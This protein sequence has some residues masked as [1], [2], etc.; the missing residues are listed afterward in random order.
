MNIKNLI[1]AMKIEK[2]VVVGVI[3]MMMCASA[4]V[5]SNVN[6]SNRYPWNGMVDVR[7]NLNQ[8]A[9]VTLTAKDT[10]GGTNLMTRTLSEAGI[11]IQNG[12]TCLSVGDRHVVWNAAV[13]YPNSVFENVEIAVSADVSLYMIINLTKSGGKNEITYCAGMPKSGWPVEYK[14]KYLVL[15]RIKSG[16]FTMGSPTSEWGRNSNETQTEQ[17]ISSDYYIGIYEVTYGQLWKVTGITSTS[18]GWSADYPAWINATQADSFVSTLTEGCG[19]TIQ[20]PTEAQWEY[21]CRAGTTS[22]LYTGSTPSSSYALRIELAGRENFAN[23]TDQTGY[24]PVGVLLPNPWG[25][26][27]MYGNRGEV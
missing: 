25:L 13:D 26:Y 23:G 4:G 11:P 9:V 12:T 15:R 14:T 16:T 20:L 6:V 24:Y 19:K 8:D 18:Y 3:G 17:T 21:A 10:V 5:V 22:A 7:F 2:C 27:D 1:P